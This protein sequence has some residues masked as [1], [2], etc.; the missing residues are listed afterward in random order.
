MPPAAEREAALSNLRGVSTRS[1]LVVMGSIAVIAL[2]TYGLRANDTAQI[3]LGQPAPDGPIER[4]GADGTGELADYRGGW[5]LVNFW[6]SWCPPCKDESPAIEKYRRQHQSELTV[7]GINVKDATPQAEE[8]V[9][10]LG[11]NWEMF[12]DGAGN[13]MDQYGILALPESFLVDPKGN[14]AL[15]RRGPVDAAYLEQNVTPL[16]EAGS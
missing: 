6:A 10:D 7:V 5:V 3:A 12:H 8:F 9:S 14:L 1:F 15:I 16:I 4:L 2:L 11:L 13:R